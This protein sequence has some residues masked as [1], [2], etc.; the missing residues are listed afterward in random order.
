MNE[1]ELV[2]R[3]TVVVALL[4][5]V[6][7]FTCCFFGV[8]PINAVVF[9][10]TFV[11]IALFVYANNIHNAKSKF[12]ER[13]ISTIRHFVFIASVYLII[14]AGVSFIKTDV[15]IIASI[16]LVLLLAGIAVCYECSGPFK[17]IY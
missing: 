6:A 15:G 4:N 3:L 11:Y 1:K 10:V 16:D 2:I 9:I 17:M 5:V 8:N 12:K 14:F 7:F 13:A